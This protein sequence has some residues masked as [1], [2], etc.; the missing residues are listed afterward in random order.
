MLAKQQQLEQLFS[1]YLASFKCYD[2]KKLQACYHIPCTLNTPDN[3]V[4]VENSADF[5]KEFE[6]IFTQ[7]QQANVQDIRASNIS[8][9]ELTDHLLLVNIDWH[10]IDDDGQA[11]A[12]FCAVYHIQA[13]EKNCRIVNVASHEL[14]SSL[15]LADTFTFKIPA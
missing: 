7:L 6:Q 14:T 5:A 9:S 13:G 8:Y 15:N 10:F 12:Q 1:A 3:L 11:F 2:L 4:Y